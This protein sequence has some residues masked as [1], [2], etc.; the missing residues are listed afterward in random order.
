MP[1]IKLRRVAYQEK[2]AGGAIQRAPLG[3]ED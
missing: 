2:S 1:A 3:A